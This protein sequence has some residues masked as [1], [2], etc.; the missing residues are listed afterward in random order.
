MSASSD[1][2][3][4]TKVLKEL[5]QAGHI[6]YFAGGCV[7]DML[8]EVPSKDYDVATNATPEQVESLFKRTIMVGAKFGVAMVVIKSDQGVDNTIEVATFR[9][10]VS[11]SDGRRPD[12]IEFASPEEDAKR[13]DFTIN[14]MFYDPFSDKII[15]YV[16]GKDDLSS[17][18]LRTI[19]QAEQRFAEDYLRMLRAVRFSS[20]LNFPIVQE[21]IDAIK[22][23]NNKICSISGERIFDELSSILGSGNRI[24]ALSQLQE[25]GLAAHILP[26]LFEEDDRKWNNSI[27]RIQ[28]LPEDSDSGIVFGALLLDL[29]KEQLNQISRRWG[30]S[31][32]WRDMVIYYSNH[33]QA[34][35]NAVD[36][37]LCLFKK[38]LW[39]SHWP[40]LLCLWTIQ[41]QIE[42]PDQSVSDMISKRIDSIDPAEIH[43]KPFVNGADLKDLGLQEGR[44]LG[45]VL[46]AVYD[47]QLN[48]SLDGFDAAMA[49]AKGLIV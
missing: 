39:N 41:D 8:L 18:I 15:D 2:T 30:V 49:M 4:A 19:G 9:N 36:M 26:E 40:E 3:T 28:R 25:L 32:S 33:R 17:G 46:T 47:A 13:R 10:D 11:Y 23:Y 12:S 48:E 27:A 43:P 45:E 20:R 35:K 22:Q 44:Q 29:N 7:R 34:W 1:K 21:T 31:N 5:R 24:I 14:G 38:I 37:E 6:A 16:G 42:S